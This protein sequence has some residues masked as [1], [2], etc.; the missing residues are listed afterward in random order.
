MDTNR[1]IQFS[2]GWLLRGDGQWI[3]ANLIDPIGVPAA[4]WLLRLQFYLMENKQR[5][6]I[7]TVEV[8]PG[9]L[10]TETPQ[11]NVKITFDTEDNKSILPDAYGMLMSTIGMIRPSPAGYAPFYDYNAAFGKIADEFVKIPKG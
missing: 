10:G 3:P 7:R 8:L 1:N 4:D 11:V 2:N 5:L 9:S 6:Y